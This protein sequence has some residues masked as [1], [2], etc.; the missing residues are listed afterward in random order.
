MSQSSLIMPTIVLVSSHFANSA[1]FRGNVKIPRQR[2]NSA[3]QLKILHPVE[4]CGS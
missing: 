2:K 4:N 1:K 3:A